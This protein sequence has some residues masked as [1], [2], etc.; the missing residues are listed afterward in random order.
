MVQCHGPGHI[1][2]RFG[3]GFQVH[4]KMDKPAAPSDS[5][6][7]AVGLPVDEAAVELP[8]DEDLELD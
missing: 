7:V 6:P 1:I 8:V 2:P 5:P 4:A 3:L